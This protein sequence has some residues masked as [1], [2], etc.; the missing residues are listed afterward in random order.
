MSHVLENAIDAIKIG[1]EDFQTGKAPRLASSI[2]N[3]YAGILLLYKEK[4]RRISPDDEILLKDC[5]KPTLKDGNV[6]FEGQG[7]KTVG[8]QGIIKRFKEFGI[9]TDFKK[10][11]EISRIRNEFEHYH[12]SQPKL[13]IQEAWWASFIIIV[14]FMNEE[15]EIDPIEWLGEDT[16]DFLVNNKNV[17]D[18]EK[19]FCI[20]KFK[21]MKYET[22]ELLP[23]L[24]SLNCTACGSGLLY[25]STD[26]S[27]FELS[28]KSCGQIDSYVE[29]VVQQI[30]DE[31]SLSPFEEF[32][33]EGQ[34]VDCCPEC[35]KEG[36]VFELNKCLLCGYE[37]K[38]EEC[39][40]CYTTIPLE[41]TGQSLCGYCR[42]L[43]EKD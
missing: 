7:Q 31:Y 33:A 19:E 23:I 22:K 36:Y 40:R 38:W 9:S 21:D 6:I 20:N 37:H 39:A 32:Y 25:P 8:K 24:N 26:Q 42:N 17:Y 41:D 4:L 18:A 2:R 3:V 15:L 13:V 11:D 35:E 29:E 30:N 27:D 16:Y 1:V 10:L 34:S 14:T 5:I 12:C 28:C 43:F